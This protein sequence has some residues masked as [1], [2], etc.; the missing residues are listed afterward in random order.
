MEKKK[1]SRVGKIIGIILLVLALLIL[2]A[3]AAV[4]IYVNSLLN[5]VDRTED[6]GNEFLSES[7]V[8]EDEP[9]Y[10]ITEPP[11][12]IEQV[13]NE[14]E[15]IQQ[16]IVLDESYIDNILLIGS[17]RRSTRENGRADSMMILS[18]NHRTQQIHI[19]SLMRAMYV[20]IPKSSGD[21]WGMLNAAYSWGGPQ[22][23]ISTIENNLRIK[24]N[25]YVAVDFSSFEKAIDL[26]GG[27]ELT[28]TKAEANRLSLG[29]AGTYNLS[30]K[31][32]L[33]YSRIRYLDND[34][35]RTSRQRKVI[36]ALLNKAKSINLPQLMD[37]ANQIL[38]AVKTNL[39]NGELLD[40]LYQAATLLSYPITQKMLPVENESGKNY[41]GRIFIN[42]RE[43][44]RVDFD[45]NIQALH[46]FLKS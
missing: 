22:L 17:D 4:L 28:L 14:Y 12:V 7:E 25:K 29:G 6:S 36:T 39:S 15:E 1:K 19:V 33:D 24:I 34:F 43:M 45:T 23:L 13:Q 46:E 20:C 10:D 41:V 9:T 30:G 35:I 44:Y 3:V 32:A 11:E 40:Y 16:E 26:V 42:G 18:I 2:A 27:V 5:L 37:L 21:V 31:K 8:Y 38:P